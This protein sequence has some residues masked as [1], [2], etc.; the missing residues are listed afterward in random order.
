MAKNSIT[1]TFK[2]HRER[3]LKFIRADEDDYV[4]D[5]IADI[6]FGAE[7]TPETEYLRSLIF[8]EIQTALFDLPE[9][10]RK[11]FEQTEF[12]NYSVKEITE[13]TGVPANTVLSRKHHAVKTLRKRLTELYGDVV[14]KG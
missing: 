12:Y 5:E 10:Q 8:D 2:T 1:E 7:A 14:G 4:F 11:V 13:E 6:V 9:E 3:L